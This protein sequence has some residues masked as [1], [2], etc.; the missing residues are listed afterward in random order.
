M[1]AQDRYF[2]GGMGGVSTLSADARSEIS[3]GSSAVSLYKPE[4]GPTIQLF[5]GLHLTDYAS[6]QANYVWCRNDVLLTSL[7]VADGS[8]ASY[9]QPRDSAQRGVSGD[10]LIYFRNRSSRIRPYLAFGLGAI[11]FHSRA[12]QPDAGSVGLAAPAAEFTS[13]AMAV[14]FPV[15][16]D[17]SVGHGWWIRYSFTETMRQNPLSERLSPPGQRRL[18]IFQNLFGFVKYF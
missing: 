11:R 14:R 10:L 5:G 1:P 13:T 7:L 17:I 15:G 12:R 8:A 9:Q 3:A 4:N 16:I 6:M 2:L 18:A